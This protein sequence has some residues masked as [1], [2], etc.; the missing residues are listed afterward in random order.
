MKYKNNPVHAP[1]I[2]PLPREKCAIFSEVQV[3]KKA[4]LLMFFDIFSL[5]NLFLVV[6]G[7]CLPICL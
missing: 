6:A 4:E 7:D 2:K 1:P 5:F 3:C